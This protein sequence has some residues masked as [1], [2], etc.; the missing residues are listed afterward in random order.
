[1]INNSFDQ[2]GKLDLKS[3]VTK[4]AVTK[5]NTKTMKDFFSF[6]KTNNIEL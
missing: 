4:S 1:M 2:Q 5:K 6:F 3:A